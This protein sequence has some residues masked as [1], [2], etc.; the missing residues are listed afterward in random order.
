M[1]KENNVFIGI[2]VSKNKL[3]ISVRA[4]HYKI[5][6]NTHAI[7]NFIKK[8]LRELNANI[9]LCVVESTGGYEKLVMKLLQYA[10]IKVHRAHPNKVYAFAKVKGHFAKTDK[11]D[12]TLLE[13]YAAFVGDHEQGDA[14][15]SAAQEELKALKAIEIDLQASIAANKNRI[16]HLQGRALAYLKQQI[17]FCENQLKQIRTAMDKLIEQDEDLAKRRAIIS[18]YKG[19][20]KRVSSM[21]LINLPELGK[22]NN[23]QIAALIGV[24]PKTNESGRKVFRAHIQGGRFAVRHALYMSALVASRYNERIKVFYERL[25][26]AG[27]A[28]KIALVAVMR[29][30]IVCL[31]AMLKNN[32]FFA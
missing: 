6:N 2:D 23:K 27:K 19:V 32:S 31:N 24:A 25:L 13:Q 12:A 21:L 18:S 22:L 10:G 3:D 11:L 15:V 7:T 28:P 20:G 30:I 26:V 5:N 4:K 17:K 29:K 8:E 1:N 16:Q 9:R 14:I